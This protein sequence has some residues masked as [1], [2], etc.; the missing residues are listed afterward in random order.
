MTRALELRDHPA[1]RHGRG[2]LDPQPRETFADELARLPMV[3]L[4]DHSHEASAGDVDRVLGR[5]APERT[6]ADF[7]ALLSPALSP[8]RSSLLRGFLVPQRMGVAAECH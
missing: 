4:L 7:A 8:P 1:D 3:R 5:P 2:F 6:L